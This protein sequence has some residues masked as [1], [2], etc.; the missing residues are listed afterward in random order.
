MSIK[1]ETIVLF[2]IDIGKYACS[3]DQSTGSNRRHG[4]CIGGRHADLLAQSLVLRM[5]CSAGESS[6]AVGL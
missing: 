5:M 6:T 4:V 3:Y 1:N 2:L